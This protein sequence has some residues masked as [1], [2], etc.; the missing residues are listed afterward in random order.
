MKVDAYEEEDDA[1]QW[2]RGRD[3][4]IQN[5]SRP[6]NVVDIKVKYRPIRQQYKAL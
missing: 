4:I 6:D 2:Q 5:R 3:G 1:M